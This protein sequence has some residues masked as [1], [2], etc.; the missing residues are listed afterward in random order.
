MALRR[1]MHL[2]FFVGL[3]SSK[4]RAVL[5]RQ[6]TQLQLP[7]D[8]LFGNVLAATV[9]FS[10]A[11]MET[12]IRE[13]SERMLVRKG[14]P[15]V[16][17]DFAPRAAA[18]AGALTLDSCLP[19]SEEEFRHVVD[20]VA[21]KFRITLGGMMI[22]SLLLDHPQLPTNAEVVDQQHHNKFVDQAFELMTP[23]R[24]RWPTG[25][26]LVL[27]HKPTPG[28][29]VQI[30]E[31]AHSMAVTD[32]VKMD[33][34]DMHETL[35]IISCFAAGSAATS[36]AGAVAAPHASVESVHVVTGA[37]LASSGVTDEATAVSHVTGVLDAAVEYDS[38][39][40][41]L[42]VSSVADIQRDETSGTST[43]DS[44]NFRIGRPLAFRQTMDAFI[45][46]AEVRKDTNDVRLKHGLK[47]AAT[48]K[49]A[50][51]VV[52]ISSD[53]QLTK[54]I[55]AEASE[56]WRPT[57]EEQD[58]MDAELADHNCIN[59]GCGLKFKGAEAR[60]E[61]LCKY[62]A[63]KHLVLD[64]STEGE[65]ALKLVKRA[66]LDVTKLHA[67]FRE[68]NV[69]SNGNSEKLEVSCARTEEHQ[70][71]VM[72]YSLL[73]WEC[74]GRKYDPFGQPN[75]EKTGCHRSM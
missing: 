33:K 62:H 49:H 13:C 69:M 4:S 6:A 65:A 30:R 15:L 42:D 1:R 16:G 36:A 52:L 39:L 2:T 9:N 38:S 64:R 47:D 74:C 45:G 22:S 61:S 18:S 60:D 55:K 19:L 41:A 5:L 20:K 40:V 7:N 3:P 66:C 21:R 24:Y 26:V 27:L 43:G 29:Y 63:S 73:V 51:W 54:R 23:T 12:L 56:V 31:A 8:P 48:C 72:L 17:A 50:R 25:R 58:A 10:G 35:R 46:S 32:F 11:A 71:P 53:A 14:L 67:I 59:N 44:S 75:G 68:R 57:K 70:V 34:L 28:M 37:S